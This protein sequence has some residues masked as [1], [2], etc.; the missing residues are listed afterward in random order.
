[1]QTIRAIIDAIIL[2]TKKAQIPLNIMHRIS[3]NDLSHFA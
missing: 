2:G 3:L 1:M